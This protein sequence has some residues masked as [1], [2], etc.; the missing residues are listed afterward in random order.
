MALV[1]V[2]LMAMA[3]MT[4]C[5][6]IAGGEGIHVMFRGIP[7]I[8]HPDVFYHGRVVG[9]ILEQPSVNGGATKVTIR[10]SPEYREHAGHHWAFYVDM[11]RLTA[12]RLSSSGEPIAAGD[13][14]C[15]FQT[16]TAFNWF[17]VK[18][19]L[20]DR[21]AEAGRKAERLHRRFIQSG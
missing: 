1:M 18:T 10:I 14:M 16:K 3:A 7:K 21:I 4:G 9:S 5:Q 19:L 11:G 20:S 17:K 12:G 2:F 15:G 8:H 6:N 13:T